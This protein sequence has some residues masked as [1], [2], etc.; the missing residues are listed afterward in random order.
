MTDS[1]ECYPSNAGNIV[2]LIGN[3]GKR[4]TTGN[5]GVVRVPAPNAKKAAAA[6]KKAVT[7]AAAAKQSRRRQESLNTT[8]LPPPPLP[9]SSAAVWTRLHAG[10]RA[11]SVSGPVRRPRAGTPSPG[12]P[13]AAP[14]RRVLNNKH[15]CHPKPVCRSI[16]SAFLP[17]A[18]AERAAEF[19]IHVRCLSYVRYMFSCHTCHTTSKSGIYTWSR[20]ISFLG[21]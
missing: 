7:A 3:I 9:P 12:C 6:A 16:S 17:R 5:Q 13:M 14:P 19:K 20:Y 1:E 8:E 2:F 11:L 15:P 4:A 21:T 10:F 18:A